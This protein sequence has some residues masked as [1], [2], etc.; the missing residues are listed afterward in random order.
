MTPVLITPVLDALIEMNIAAAAAIIFLLAVRKPARRIFG[1]HAIY[2]LWAIVPIAAA[3]T[4]IPSRTI[5]MLSMGLT[6][7]E[8]IALTTPPAANSALE[9]MLPYTFLAAWL[10]GAIATAVA[11]IRRQAAFMRDAE[12]GL[13]GPAIVGFSQPRIVTPDDFSRRFNT[14]ERKLILTHEQVHLERNDARIN[15]LVAVVRCLFWFNP[16]IHIGAKAMRVDQELSC[17]AEVIDRRPRVR[18]AYAETLLK[19]QLA[20]RPLPVGCYWPAESQHP[21]AERI[22]MLAR[23]PLSTRRRVAATAIALSLTAGAG[24]AAWAAQPE[25]TI[26]TEAPDLLVPFKPIPRVGAEE[27]DPLVRVRQ[28]IDAI[29]TKPRPGAGFTQPDYP[30]ASQA[31]REE[32]DV[33][34]ELCVAAS[35]F[36]DTVKL[37]QSSGHTRLDDATLAGFQH[38]RFVPATREGRPI[39]HCGYNLT[40]GWRLNNAP[41]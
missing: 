10:I 12:L 38:S 1:P 29:T 21:L 8:V 34:V 20:S 16:V 15:A 40:M 24:V 33:V 3:A 22:D 28:Q 32:G 26:I 23:K 31:L 4:F 30:A 41:P 14:T 6:L 11:L 27:Q 17:D 18:R 2:L 9:A 35:G 37:V 19:T 39:R 36:V 25:R 5:E 13:A 7:D